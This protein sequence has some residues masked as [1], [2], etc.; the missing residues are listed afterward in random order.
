MEELARALTGWRNDPEPN[1]R[2]ARNGANWGKPMV[3]STWQPERDSGAKTVM[4]RSLAAGRSATQDLDD[5]VAM[6]M[7]HPNIAKVLDAGTI[8]KDEGGRMK[9]EKET[10]NQ[11]DSSF[12]PHP[13]SFRTGRPFFVME[14][15]RGLPITEF[16]DQNQL[17]T[18]ER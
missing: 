14:L 17:T 6:L 10:P 12:I 8:E 1:T 2:P 16:C 11:S 18:H 7:D 9:D 3:P 15:V 13:S 5:I 4:G